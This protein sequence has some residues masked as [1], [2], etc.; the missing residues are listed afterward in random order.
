MDFN[1]LISSELSNFLLY[2]VCI[3]FWTSFLLDLLSVQNTQEALV[4]MSPGQVV[5]SSP[6]SLI[7]D[8]DDW[9]KIHC[10]VAKPSVVTKDGLR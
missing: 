4:V 3:I 1:I 9:M 5:G 8:M 10:Q 2:L 6:S 7:L